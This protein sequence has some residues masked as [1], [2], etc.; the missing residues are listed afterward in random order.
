MK[1]IT[2]HPPKIGGH[3]LPEIDLR[4]GRLSEIRAPAGWSTM[5]T[6]ELF[7]QLSSKI[8]AE[9]LQIAIANRMQSHRIS[10][11]DQIWRR[12]VDRVLAVVAGCSI[13]DARSVCEQAQVDWRQAAGS[14]PWTD[15]KLLDYELSLP[16]DV[17]AVDDLGLDPLGSERVGKHIQRRLSNSNVAVVALRYPASA[18]RPT[19]SWE[20]T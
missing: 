3:E 14:L 16:A 9:G 4:A 8:R 13:D 15:K 18:L 2:F 12:S 6:E 7:S 17:I 10:W 1:P 19:E 5:N 20:T 11:M